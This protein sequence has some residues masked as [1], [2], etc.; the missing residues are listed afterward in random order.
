MTDQANHWDQVYSS[1]SADDVSWYQQDAGVSLSLIDE[2]GPPGAV[3]DVGAGASALVD[4]LLRDGRTDVTLL[5][6]SGEGL[7]T[8]RQRL[9][10][11]AVGSVSF[12]V[13]DLLSWSPSRQFAV[14]HDRAVFHFLTRQVE[15]DAYVAAVTA[16]VEPGG[17]LVLG[18]FAQDG[19]EMCS[20]LPTA[21]YDSERLAAL[22]E[23]HFQV[24]T[25]EREVHRTPW[26][27]EQPFTWLVLRRI[28]RG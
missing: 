20:G 25:A 2:Y 5:D 19:P 23:E 13:A 21:R 28:P 12:V 15:R 1:K 17:V 14:W 7:E 18:T 16:A 11:A 22:F 6:I 27:A 26:G 9:G 4:G 10:D 3:V 24:E 8:T